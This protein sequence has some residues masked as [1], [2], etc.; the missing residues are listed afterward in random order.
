MPRPKLLYNPHHKRS[1]LVSSRACGGGAWYHLGDSF[2][3]YTAGDVTSCAAHRYDES[4]VAVT[5]HNEGPGF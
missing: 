1:G 5:Q 4:M 3:L 2:L